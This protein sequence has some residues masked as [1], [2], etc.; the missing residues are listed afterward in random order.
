VPNNF[1]SPKAIFPWQLA[2]WQQLWQTR[3][4]NRL[5]HALLFVGIDGIGKKQFAQALANAVLCAN[6]TPDGEWCG[7]CHT[8]R[9]ISAKT[10]PDLVFVEPEELGKAISVDQVRAVMQAVCETTLKGGYRVIIIHPA[11]SMNVNAAN[12]LL[13]T[14]E[15]PAPKTLLIL[16]SNQSLRIPATVISRCQ[17]IQ[18][19]RPE[20]N[21]AISW[22]NEQVIDN[23]IDTQ[24][25]LKLAHGAPL[26]ALALIDRDLLTLR[27]DMYENFYSL[28]KGEA[29]PVQ[30]AAKWQE[31][32]Q[33]SVVDLLLSWL[34]DLLR[35][36]MTYDHAHLVN[37]DHKNEIMKVS[38]SLL[39]SNLI[40]YIDEVQQKRAD[41]L[42]AVNLNKQLFLEDLF[43]RWTNY[44]PG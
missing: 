8:C 10:H 9:M 30:L 18:F 7:T 1:I 31:M 22:L 23:K 15:E 44:V 36:K 29:D 16:L 14:L 26:K 2:I 40:A 4:Q 41:L 32:D 35:Y 38:V 42:S 3:L 39:Q 27:Q 17:K 19:A 13:K 28:T 12:A 25:L 37:V 34:T 11:T 21:Q 20:H 24:L 43:I 33:I 5:A 6:T